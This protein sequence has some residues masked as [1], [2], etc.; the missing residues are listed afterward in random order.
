MAV[1]LPITIGILA[2]NEAEN[3]PTCLKQCSFAE[4]II[5]FIDSTS[6]DQTQQIVKDVGVKMIRAKL[7]SFADARNTILK[8]ASQEWVLFLDA[9]ERLTSI[10]IESIE[11]FVLSPGQNVGAEL[12]RQDVFLGRRLKH[13][14]ANIWLIRLGRRNAGF[15]RRPVHEIWELKGS[16]TKLN[17][18]LEHYSHKSVQDYLRKMEFY[19]DLD[20]TKTTERSSWWQLPVYP[21]MKFIKVYIFQLGILDGWPGLV[22]AYLN[23]RYSFTKRRK[24]LRGNK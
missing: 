19:T 23:A 15:W 3:L 7:E 14:D 9:D 6:T 10:L 17:G 22:F 16:T 18:I 2:K 24:L 21:L 12:L 20:A 13:G 5:V 1:K 8:E 4:E 11:K